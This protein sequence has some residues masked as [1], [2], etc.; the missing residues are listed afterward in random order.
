MDIKDYS[1]SALR[2][3]IANESCN[4]SDLELLSNVAISDFLIQSAYKKKFNY[5]GKKLTFSP[6]VF[7][8]LTFLCRDVCHYC[9]FAQ[10]PKNVESPYLSIDQVVEIAKEGQLKGCHEALFT[11]GD[12]PELRYNAARNALKDMGYSS[13]NEYLA[14]CAQ[15]VLDET[16]LIPHL[17][18]GCLTPEELTMLKPL[19]GSMGLMVESL[20]EELMKKGQAH[21]GSPD[22]DPTFRL[23][24]IEEAG[25]QKIPFTTGI[26]IGIGE[27]RFERLEA[28]V[29]IAELHSLYGH[30]Q[31]VIV[32]NFKAKPNTL[33]ANS[34]EPSFD[35]LLWTV[36]MARLILPIDISLQ[37]PPNLNSGHLDQLIM[38]GINDFGGISP[39][40]K[41]F[42]NPEAPW[43]EIELLQETVTSL[44]QFLLPRT[45][46]YP[47]YFSKLD[48]FSTPD[49]SS[50]L[51]RKVDAQSL[52]REDAWVSG[53]SQSTPN[54]SDL[55]STSGIKDVITKAEAQLDI[56]SISA[57]LESDGRD[58]K[59]IID[60][61]NELN[62]DLHG[63]TVTCV[64]NRN[65]NYTNICSFKC[66][67]CAFSKGK[68]HDDLRGKPYNISRD[69]IVR[70]TKE[71][72]A[73]GA[74]EVCMQGGI[75]PAYTGQT[76]LDII[77]SVR[78]VSDTIHIHAFSPL[79]IDHGRK[80]LNISTEEFLLELKKSGLNS[81]PGT[82]AE[83]LHDDIRA[84]I[85][86][87]KLNSMEWINIIKAAHAVGLPTTSTMM[88]GHVENMKHVAHHLASIQKIQLE[89][90]GIT[91]FVPLP[92]VA[93]EAPIYRRGLSRPGPTFKEAVVVHS[94]SRILFH[95][96]IK[97]IQGSW[98]KMGLPGL[99]V[100]LSAGINDV[101]GV[102]MNESITKAA[103]ASFGQ[104][105]ELDKV[106]EITQS[107]GLNLVQRNTLYRTLNTNMS[108]LVDLQKIP[109]EPIV[110]DYH[111][112]SQ[113]EATHI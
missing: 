76:Y 71:A 3:L 106:L 37:V 100:L 6:K 23:Q 44:N 58:F 99:K 46:L 8:P 25:K 16:S 108:K 7:I 32:Q 52:L 92:F 105:L 12:K 34:P 75:H 38:S 29:K 15:A 94:V 69:E 54:Y 102:L 98:V 61:A 63:N 5:Y 22:K 31:E 50:R 48:E 81:L 49:I 77:E 103:G 39:V 89:T 73:R 65:I 40:T 36:A 82:A 1:N 90:S 70:R 96:T 55:R 91:E 27:T 4:A 66:N 56:D 113:L 83:I 67:F 86:P 51:L 109:L 41:D 21:H 10:T 42:V 24:T 87:D 101:G 78:S 14:A 13:T 107:L 60:Y 93:E 11:L 17:N 59:Y 28:L 110:N 68:G 2:N 35:D 26:L 30:I 112:P 47:N 95:N 33:M 84:V 97:N 111:P 88:F 64:V 74:T 9:T 80:T 18:P 79:E 19:S 43:P 85:C 53:V 45:T 57:L 62:R 72:V 104:E 20:S